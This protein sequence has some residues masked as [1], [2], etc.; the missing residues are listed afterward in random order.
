M[1]DQPIHEGELVGIFLRADRIAVRQIEAGEADG[2]P[3][4]GRDDAL[5]IARLLVGGIAGQAGLGLERPLGEQGDSVE[6]LLPVD[7]D[8]VAE[9][10]DLGARKSLGDALDLLQAERVGPDFAKIIQKMRQALADRIDVPGGDDQG[11]ALTNPNVCAPPSLGR[12][13]ARMASR[14]PHS[15]VLFG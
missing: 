2:A 4:V 15:P 6:R 10:L 9:R 11:S 3:C 13:R 5:D 14:Q 1:R 8:I 12:R 7:R